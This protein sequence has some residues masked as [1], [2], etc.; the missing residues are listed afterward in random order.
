MSSN[1]RRDRAVDLGAGHRL[2]DRRRVPR[3]GHGA[4]GHLSAPRDLRRRRRPDHEQLRR[5]GG[6]RQGDARRDARPGRQ[7][8]PRQRVSHRR[9]GQ[10]D[11]ERTRRCRPATS[12][13]ISRGST[14]CASSRRATARRRPRPACAPATTSAS[15][16]TCR[17][18]RCRCSKACAGCAA[19][20]ARRSRSRSSAATPTD[21]HVVELTREAI[22]T[23][24]VTGTDRRA[25]RR[26]PAHRG[27]RPR[28]R[29][30]RRR[31]RSPIS[32]KS[33]ASKLIVDVRRT[34]GGSL[35]GGIALARLFVGKRHA[36][37]ARNDAAR[38][39]KR[40]PRA[41]GD[42]SDHAAD[43]AAR[44]HRHVGRRRAL[45]VGARR[46]QARRPHRRAHD[47]PRRRS[48]SWC[49]L[50]DGSGLWL[51][52]TRYLTPA[53]TPLHEKGLEPTVAVDEP[54]V[55]FGQPAPTTDPILD[56][57]L[58]RLGQKKAA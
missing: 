4:R 46:Q 53:G 25:G 20:R 7:P 42:G 52:T 32:S 9:S 22:P 50:P 36:G 55:E 8:R 24:D 18:A 43:D 47:R 54:D 58:E 2:R 19:R 40:L 41:A 21:P 56:K 1:T 34:S 16:T 3:Q 5:E 28:T 31:R 10:A 26:L 17:R 12:A 6:R 29:P 15:S 51:T 39:A 45:R 23:T 33:G 35:D 38:A 14:T 48:R 13:S 37:H 11:R 49:K 44:R 57:A 30:T 27:R